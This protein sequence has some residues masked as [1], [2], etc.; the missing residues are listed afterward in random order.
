MN[1]AVIGK[2]G[3]EHALVKKLAESQPSRIFMF[4]P[5]AMR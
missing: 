5:V 2:G 3:R 4:I 1:I